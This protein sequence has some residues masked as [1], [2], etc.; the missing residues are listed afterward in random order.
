MMCDSIIY[1]YISYHSD[2]SMTLVDGQI[3]VLDACMTVS[4]GS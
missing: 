1:Q 3:T 4:D 2:A